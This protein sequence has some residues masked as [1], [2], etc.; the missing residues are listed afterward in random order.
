MNLGRFDVQ[1][2]FVAYTRTTSAWVSGHFHILS[3]RSVW[4]QIANCASTDIQRLLDLNIVRIDSDNGLDPIWID[5]L[6]ATLLRSKAAEVFYPGV[7]LLM[8]ASKVAK[9]YTPLICG[10]AL[11]GDL[12]R[13]SSYHMH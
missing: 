8:R 4:S 1:M 2:D 3:L 6:S 10:A 7:I 5:L 13:G 9:G 12:I 11:V